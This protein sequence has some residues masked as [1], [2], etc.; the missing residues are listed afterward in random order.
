MAVTFTY[1]N[2]FKYAVFKKL[3]DL[4]A[5]EIKVLLMRDG[6][7]FD[8]DVH[9]LKEN[10][11]GVEATI[12]TT[13][14]NTPSKFT[15][16]GGFTAAGFVV[17]NRVITD[18]AHAVNQGPFLI[19]VITDTVMTVTDMAGDDVTLDVAT[20]PE[21]ITLTATDELT[22]TGDGGYAE[23][24]KTTGAIV[25]TSE[26]DAYDRCDAAFPTVTWTCAGVAIGPTPGAILYLN[27]A[28]SSYTIIGY[29][30]FGG[31]VTATGTDTINIGN[32]TLRLS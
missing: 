4:S 17:G 26:N 18:S 27:T 20:E 29:F 6:F 15:T 16:A 3:V 5:D 1:S 32:G 10:I 11:L 22:A 7:V 14:S 28:G 25:M 30:D 2:R 19:S 24:T 9:A 12:A 13:A 8:K 23:D 31:D 21:T